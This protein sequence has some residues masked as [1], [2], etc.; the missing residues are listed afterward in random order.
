[1]KKDQKRSSAT[2]KTDGQLQKDLES[3]ESVSR[4][5]ADNDSAFDDR[6]IS[7][8][9]KQ[10]IWESRITKAALS[11]NASMSEI[12][13][14]QILSGRRHPSRSCLLSIGIGMSCSLDEIQEMLLICG[15][16][17]LRVRNRRDAIIMHGI[18]H[19]QDLFRINDNL[20]S[21]KQETLN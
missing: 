2:E 8:L 14:Y 9:L 12:Y 7:D 13:L 21:A 16:A 20:F 3:A 17:G 6:S 5:I 1:M 11:R 15:Y 4:F 19:G 18:L 10:K